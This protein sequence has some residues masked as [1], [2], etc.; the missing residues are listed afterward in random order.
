MRL[1]FFGLCFGGN[2]RRAAATCEE[3]PINRHLGRAFSPKQSSLR[4]LMASKFVRLGVEL[5][6]KRVGQGIQRAPDGGGQ[7]WRRPAN[8]VVAGRAGAIK[9]RCPRHQRS[10]G[11]VRKQARS[12]G[13]VRLDACGLGAYGQTDMPCGGFCES[14]TPY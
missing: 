4:Q 13:I 8:E 5:A 12:T 9:I 1:W 14:C 6:T 2:A 11:I 7:P 3:M 10:V